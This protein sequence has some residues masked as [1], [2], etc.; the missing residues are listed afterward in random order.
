M[1]IFVDNCQ[2]M[3]IVCTN[4]NEHVKIA[5]LQCTYVCVIARYAGSDAG[6]TAMN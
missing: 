2:D 3:L 6:G 5:Q 4:R 1:E